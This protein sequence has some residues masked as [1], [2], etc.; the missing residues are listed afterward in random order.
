MENVNSVRH[1]AANL[2][3]LWMGFVIH[4]FFRFRPWILVVVVVGM[5]REIVLH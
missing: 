5:T 2:E 4:L 3:F 1:G